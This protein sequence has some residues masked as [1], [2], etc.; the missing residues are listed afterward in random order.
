[1]DNV[2]VLSVNPSADNDLFAD[3]TFTSEEGKW[4]SEAEYWATYYEHPDF[5]YEWN[6][7][8]LEAKPMSDYEQYALYKWLVMLLDQFLR[9]RPIAR[10]IALETGFRLPLPKKTSIRKPDLGV[11]LHDNPIWLADKDRSY[12]GIFDLCI[13]SLSDSDRREV[14]RDTVQKRSEYEIIGVREYYIL[15]ARQTNLRFYQ[16]TPAGKYIALPPVQGDIIQSTV[17]P[18]FQFRLSDLTRQPSLIEM[19]ADEVY[20]AFILP[21]YQIEKQRAE[22]ER[23]R[24]EQERQRAERLAAKLKALGFSPDE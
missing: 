14:E 23:Q 11:V 15:D 16:R 2:Q 21:E 20:Q 7:G 3:E 5:S 24:A 6:N 12:K 9:I 17:L 1:M 13:E 8:Y 18:G 10:M 19:A 22:Q 4:V